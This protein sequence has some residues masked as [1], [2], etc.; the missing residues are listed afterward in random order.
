MNFTEVITKTLGAKLP[1][2]LLAVPS[3][4]K[5]IIKVSVKLCMAIAEMLMLWLASPF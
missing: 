5:D 4:Y 2:F 1:S 3:V